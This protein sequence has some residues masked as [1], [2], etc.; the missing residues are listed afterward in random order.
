MGLE[1]VP[2]VAGGHEG[3]PVAAFGKEDVMMKS[4]GMM[5]GLAVAAGLLL[6]GTVLAQRQV[7]LVQRL[8]K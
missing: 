6:P 1:D 4:A 8:L 5:A 2:Y 7:R 3:E